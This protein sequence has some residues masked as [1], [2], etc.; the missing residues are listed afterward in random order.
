MG[1]EVGDGGDAP[2]VHQRA[3]RALERVGIEDNAY[4][5]ALEQ[6]DLPLDAFRET[7]EQ[8]YF[9]VEFF[10]RPMAALLAKLPD[11]HQR[12]DILRNV[13]EEHGDFSGARFHATTFKRFLVSLGADPARLPQLT[14]WPEVRAF[15]MV[16]VTACA[17]DELEVG[18]GCM[19]VIEHAFAGISARIGAA[20]VARGWVR[21]ADLVH[22]RLHAEID[23]R[24][25]AEF[26]RVIEPRWDDPARRYYV[27]QGLELGAY[28][29]DR[30]YRDL[31][32][33]AV[34]RT[35]G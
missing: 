12:L 14:L 31:H 26:Y 25:A 3:V 15:N 13:V 8:F 24:H 1:D 2:R 4:V 22:Y 18:V 29:F 30:L 11:P 32:R 23:D 17:H 21:E 20:V 28:I 7:Q 16:L 27:E 10:S 35:L 19:G 5:T 6:G 9:A 33:R 34:R